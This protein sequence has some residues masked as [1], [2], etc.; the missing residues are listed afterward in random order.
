VGDAWEARHSGLR[1]VPGELIK[2]EPFN[3]MAKKIE[4]LEVVIQ[5]L[6]K[7]T[8]MTDEDVAKLFESVCLRIA[9]A[10]KLMED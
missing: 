7:R 1:I 6:A 3:K 4:V 8:G 5:E 10:E 2:A 9:T